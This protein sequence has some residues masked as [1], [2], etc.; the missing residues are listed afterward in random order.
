MSL[1]ET[2]TKMA[3]GY[4][5]ARVGDH[6][7]GGPGLGG[8]G[9]G[10][11][12]GGAKIAPK[13]AAAEQAPS[14]GGMQDMIS[15]MTGGA[16]GMG[17]LQD[18]ISQMTSGDGMGNMQDMLSK[19]A[20]DSGFDLSALLGGGAATPD[21]TGDKGGLLSSAAKGGAGMAGIFASVGGGRGCQRQRRGRSV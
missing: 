9:L 4:A 5:A 20:S 19:L 11:L 16:A 8:P 21:A 17:G 14:M 6:A 13:D 3:I 18:M 12:M 1:M 2:L 15:Q 7:S 10:G